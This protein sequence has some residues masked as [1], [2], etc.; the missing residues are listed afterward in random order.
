MCL[1]KLRVDPTH[2]RIIIYTQ[3]SRNAKNALPEFTINYRYFAPSRS[4]I[5]MRIN[6]VTKL[7]RRNI[8]E[9]RGTGL[10]GKLNSEYSSFYRIAL[11]ENSNQQMNVDIRVRL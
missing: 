11:S 1:L 8:Q 10:N 6:E 3:K 9:E 7:K 2:P 4:L 5:G